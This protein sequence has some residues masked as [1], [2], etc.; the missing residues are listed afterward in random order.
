MNKMMKLFGVAAVCAFFAACASL[1]KQTQVENGKL[2]TVVVDN[3]AVLDMNIYVLRGG[4]RIRLGTANGLSKTA[5]TIP[6]GIVSGTMTVRFLADPIGSNK[7]PV[8]EEISVDEGDEVGL[9]I[10]P[11]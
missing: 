2:T 6:R 11:F 9:M 4:Q 5:L 10:P 8:S 7:T 1:G 3:R